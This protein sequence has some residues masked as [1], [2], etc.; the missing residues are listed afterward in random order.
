MFIY[1]TEHEL[2]NR[3][4]ENSRAI[5]VGGEEFMEANER[6]I[7]VEATDGHLVHIKEYSG[8]YD[9][10]QYPLLLPYGTHGWSMLLHSGRLLHQ[11]VVDNYI[12]IETRKLRWIRSH[13]SDIRAE[14]YQ[15]LQDSLNMGEND[16]CKYFETHEH[17]KSS[18]QKYT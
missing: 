10:L 3:L 4:R 7:I 11:Y 15:G 2:D 12:K 6:D 1:D 9:P 13:Q 14:L 5:L 8:Y 17:T 16:T 18:R